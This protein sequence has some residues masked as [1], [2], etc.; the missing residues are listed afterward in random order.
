MNDLI[1]RIYDRRPGEPLDLLYANLSG[2]DLRHANLNGANLRD[3]DLRGAD[4]RR[5]DLLGADLRHANLSGAKLSGADL[6]YSVGNNKEILTIQT[7]QWPVI[8]CGDQMAIG[9]KQ[10]SIHDWLSFDNKI[11]AGMDEDA[12]AFWKFWKPILKKII[13]NRAKDKLCTYTN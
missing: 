12:M 10:H 7:G 4:L 13:A 8:L 1:N 9:C 2:A 3:A 6:R 11:I 5:A